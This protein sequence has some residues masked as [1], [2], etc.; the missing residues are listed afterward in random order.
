MASH[1]LLLV[2][3]SFFSSLVFALLVRDD[4]GD[5]FRFGLLMFGGMV[6]S[7]VLLGWLMFP[8]PI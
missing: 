1:F 3:F 6:C 7:A 2:L 4:P 8:L 5:Q